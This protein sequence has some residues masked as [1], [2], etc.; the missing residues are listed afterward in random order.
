MLTMCLGE[1]WS[2]TPADPHTQRATSQ[3]EGV[4]PL[5]NQDSDPE[6]VHLSTTIERVR[7]RINDPKLK[8]SITRYGA[9]PV[10]LFPPVH[11]AILEASEERLGFRLPPLLRDL[12]ID[13]ANGGFGPGY[14]VFGLEGG[15][16]DPMVT[17][18]EGGGTLLDWY[19]AYRGEDERMPELTGQFADQE[20][21]SLFLDPD[22]ESDD[23]AWFDKLLPISH[24]GDWQLSCIDCSS[25]G[26]P[27][28]YFDGQQSRLRYES[29]TF[30]EWIEA[31]LRS[32]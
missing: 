30:D 9:R 13:V 5:L 10:E 27:V 16:A 3:L 20:P 6:A 32:D 29:P 17:R 4:S 18:G 1:G 19:Y 15:Y 31:W 11:A 12:Y 8:T 7:A 24:R 28:F 14:G 25:L 21:S 23:W 26:F 2:V 22:P